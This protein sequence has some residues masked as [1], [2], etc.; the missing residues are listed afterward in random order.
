MPF[1]TH[2]RRNV[3]VRGIAS[4][5]AAEASRAVSVRALAT[6]KRTDFFT[7]SRSGMS[8]R[9]LSI[10]FGFFLLKRVEK[11]LRSALIGQIV[12]YFQFL[13]RQLQPN[14]QLVERFDRRLLL[15]MFH[16]LDLPPGQLAA[17]MQICVSDTL[18]LDQVSEV[19]AKAYFHVCSQY[20]PTGGD[21][22]SMTD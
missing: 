13:L 14:L 2:D 15:T 20:F 6:A 7:P 16:T 4:L 3:K 12:Q 22:Y 10:G 21:C 19:A 8:I 9:T 1:M 5:I 17:L 18:T 11:V